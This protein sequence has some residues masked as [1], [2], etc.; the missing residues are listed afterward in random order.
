MA[1]WDIITLVVIGLGLIY[2]IWKGFFKIILRGAALFLAIIISKPIGNF[3]AEKFIF[4][5]FS[6]NKFEAILEAATSVVASV[7]IF[8]VLFFVLKLL[9]GLIAKGINKLLSSS[10]I[11]RV[12]GGILGLAIGIGLM[13]LVATVAEFAS[14]LLPEL[15]LS[16]AWLEFGDT[17]LFRF[18]L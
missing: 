4:G 16:V 10:K 8:I 5:M 14:V 1:L 13:F 3:V 15:G 9:A 18:F 17:F 11:D 2:G 7:V 12:L 6:G